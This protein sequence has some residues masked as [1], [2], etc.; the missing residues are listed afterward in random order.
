MELIA[1]GADTDSRC[2]P[3]PST[4]LHLASEYGHTKVV[5]ILLDA[6]A[7]VDVQDTEEGSTPLHVASHYGDDVPVEML[8][9]A[10]YTLKD[11]AG[12]T[13]IECT[14]YSAIKNLLSRIAPLETCD[15]KCGKSCSYRCFRINPGCPMCKTRC[16]H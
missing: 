2:K 3:C 11:L 1:A 5:K 4:P 16:I 8:L 15:E 13:P 7:D 12:C 10:D 6:G 9:T 14:T